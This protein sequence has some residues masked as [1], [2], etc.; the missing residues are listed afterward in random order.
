MWHVLGK[1]PVASC[2]GTLSTLICYCVVVGKRRGIDEARY[3]EEE[4][5]RMYSISVYAL[6]WNY[7][8]ERARGHLVSNLNRPSGTDN[9]L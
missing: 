6:G 2:M 7:S 9:L 5:G 1:S 4:D 8:N 3:V